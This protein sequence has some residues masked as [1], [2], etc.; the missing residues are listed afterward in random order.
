MSPLASRVAAAVVVVAGAAVIALA[1]RCD[2]AWFERHVGV[3]FYFA[4]APRWAMPLRVFAVTAGIALVVLSTTIGR[5]L[6][7]LGRL[8]PPLPT[9]VALMAAFAV[10]E[11]T[12]R[13]AGSRWRDPAWAGNELRVGHEDAR[14][15][16]RARPGSLTEVNLG[17]RRYGYAVGPD[18]LR[19]RTPSAGPDLGR[20]SLVVVGESV[21]TGYGLDFDDT[22]AARAAAALGLEPIIVAEG[23]YGTDQAYL[24]FADVLP[25]I[26]RPVAVVTVFVPA[27]LGRV[28]RDDRPHLELDAT[29]RLN[30]VPADAG[31]LSRS[32]LLT[33][34]RRLPY[35]SSAAIDR[36]IALVRAV[37]GE[38]VA[39]ARA[40][41][42]APLFAVLSLG[43]V[44]PLD[45]HPEADIIRALFVEPGFPYVLIDVDTSERFEVDRHPNAAGA[46]R[47]AASIAGALAPRV[48]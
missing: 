7:R 30:F 32:R 36:S 27:Q 28:L 15:G 31:L 6:A 8:M 39:Q 47:M 3:P 45:A 19:A 33:M 26:G 1:W 38:T 23:G 29:G 35:A 21:A 4:G 44:R 18:G 41:G 22:F 14:Y 37:F 43:P 13:I 46:R 48:R 10:S 20:P 9:I 12:V 5:G 25:R 2:R 24:R 42:A 11:A 34:F 40:R 16:W 17:G